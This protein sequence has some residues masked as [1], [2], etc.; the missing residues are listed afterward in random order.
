MS[1]DEGCGEQQEIAGNYPLLPVISELLLLQYGL[2]RNSL[3]SL[4]NTFCT[5]ISK[6]Q[7]VSV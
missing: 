6:E 7:G 5:V 2:K 1:L 4:F 3:L